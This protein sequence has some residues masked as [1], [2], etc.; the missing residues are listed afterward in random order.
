MCVVITPPLAR[1]LAVANE[2]TCCP[3]QPQENSNG[4]LP[5]ILIGGRF[6]VL[7]SATLVS[8]RT[9]ASRAVQR[10]L[11]DGTQAPSGPSTRKH[12]RPSATRAARALEHR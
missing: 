8:Y 1:L 10:C 2:E 12:R 11:R 5:S 4:K 6:S 3:S 7:P 9:L